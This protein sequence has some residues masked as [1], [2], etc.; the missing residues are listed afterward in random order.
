MKEGPQL[1][2]ASELLA[3]SLVN[4]PFDAKRCPLWRQTR[5]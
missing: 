3:E 4:Q 5:P 2:R 1:S